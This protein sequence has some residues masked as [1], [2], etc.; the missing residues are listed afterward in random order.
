LDKFTYLAQK[1]AELLQNRTLSVFMPPPPSEVELIKKRAEL[2]QKTD[3]FDLTKAAFM[4]PWR[5][6]TVYGVVDWASNASEP[7][8]NNFIKDLNEHYEVYHKQLEKLGLNVYQIRDALAGAKNPQH[9]EELIRHQ[10]VLETQNNIYYN[11]LSDGERMAGGIASAI[12]DGGIILAATIIV[13][14]VIG[15]KFRARTS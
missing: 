7:T 13:I 3:T 8:D 4:T 5:D 1:N 6:S 9:L 2:R 11:A 10:R 12:V 15:A 14:G